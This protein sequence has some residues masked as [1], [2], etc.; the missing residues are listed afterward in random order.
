[1]MNY[2]LLY[3]VSV[4]I[5][6]NIFIKF[7]FKKYDLYK[8][9]SLKYRSLYAFSAFLILYIISIAIFIFAKN[10]GFGVFAH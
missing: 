2:S 1:M 4:G 3:F 7:L 9:L 10:M 8:N 5:F 6:I